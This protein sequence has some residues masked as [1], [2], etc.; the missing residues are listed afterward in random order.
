MIVC[1]SQMTAKKGKESLLEKA[2]RALIPPTLKEPGCL[3]YELWKDLHNK[4]SFV[5]YERFKDQEA[6]KKHIEM[7]YVRDFMESAYTT[8][9]ESHWDLNL[10]IL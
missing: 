4:Q 7:S 9:V 10:S 5:V 3:A 1:L 8:C 2:L 6:L